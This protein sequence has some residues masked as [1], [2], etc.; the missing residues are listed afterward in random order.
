MG[1]IEKFIEAWRIKEHEF[2]V[3]GGLPTELRRMIELSG[4]QISNCSFF[5]EIYF[6][7]I[8]LKPCCM[9]N[10]PKEVTKLYISQVYQL[11]K[12]NDNLPSFI[13]FGITNSDC[14]SEEGED[15]GST[16][17]CYN[18]NHISFP[19]VREWILCFDVNNHNNN[20]NNNN[21]SSKHHNDNSNNIN[22]FQVF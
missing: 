18:T 2:F 4:L 10:L 6:V 3:E 16:I 20:S 9:L 5:G 7:C 17:Y 8:G 14:M 12:K 21:N 13:G 1:Q 11:C 19:L 15:L 22:R